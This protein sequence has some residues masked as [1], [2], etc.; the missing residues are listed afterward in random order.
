MVNSSKP[1]VEGMKAMTKASQGK[2]LS[3][4][5]FTQPRA[6]QMYKFSITPGTCCRA[7]NNELIKDYKTCH[8]Y[9]RK[10]II[11]VPK[12]KRSKEGSAMLGMKQELQQLMDIFVKYIRPQFAHQKEENL[13]IHE[14]GFSI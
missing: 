6:L 8:S 9:D 13:F 14:D 3:S 11:L 12:C 1:F 4:I 10:K 5:E 7:L 2:Q